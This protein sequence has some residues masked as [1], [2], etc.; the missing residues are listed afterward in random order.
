ML[1]KPFSRYQTPSTDIKTEQAQMPKER[2]ISR[3]SWSKKAKSESAVAHTMKYETQ[4][5]DPD[6]CSRKGRNMCIQN[7]GEKLEDLNGHANNACD[8]HGM[9]AVIARR[10]LHYRGYANPVHLES[11]ATRPSNRTS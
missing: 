5:N 2:K 11:L 3:H 8:A 4:Y 1:K 10:M 6:L 9:P 7:L